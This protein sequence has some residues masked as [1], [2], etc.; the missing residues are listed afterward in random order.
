M[1]WRVTPAFWQPRIFSQYDYASKGF[2][3]MYPTAHDRFGITD[4]FDLLPD[5]GYTVVILNN[6]DSAPDPI[7]YKLHEW[8]TQGR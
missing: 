7:A 6:I 4:Q 1:A 8:L 5:L 3:T 2:E